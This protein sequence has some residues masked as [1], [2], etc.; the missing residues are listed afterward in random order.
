MCH[1]RLYSTRRCVHADLQLFLGREADHSG[2][3][4]LPSPP[5]GCCSFIRGSLSRRCTK[6]TGKMERGRWGTTFQAYQA[7][8]LEQFVVCEGDLAKSTTMQGEI[9]S[10]PQ[11]G[12]G[13]TSHLRR[14]A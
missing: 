8:E 10:I 6:Q 4:L 12:G 5:G 3:S 13:V 9:V 7:D 11:H 14:S 1:S 2:L